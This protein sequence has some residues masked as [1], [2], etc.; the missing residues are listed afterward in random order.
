M[1]TTDQVEIDALK[2]R[3]MPSEQDEVWKQKILHVLGIYP[4][5]SPSMIQIGIGP[6]IPSAVWKPIMEKM[7]E[8]GTLKRE[9][10]SLKGPTGRDNNY[11]VISIA[12]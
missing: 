5:L 1:D 6:S 12:E 10:L 8:D 2:E 7:I 4:R 3:L 11:A 9:N